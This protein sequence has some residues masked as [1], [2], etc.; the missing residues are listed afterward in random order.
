MKILKYKNLPANMEKT[1]HA[2]M[3]IKLPAANAKTSD[4]LA[5]VI[6]GPTSTSALLILLSKGNSSSCLFTA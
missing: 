3:E 6:D 2:G 1:R 5:N 4:K